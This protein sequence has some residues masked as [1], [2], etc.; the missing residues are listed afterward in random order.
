MLKK[1]PAIQAFLS[2]VAGYKRAFAI[3]ALFFATSDIVITTIPWM[4]GQLA[5]SLTE[6]HDHIVLWTTLLIAASIGHDILWRTGELLHLKLLLRRGHRFDDEIF[7]SILRQPYGYFIDKFTGKVSSYANTLGREFREMID[8]FNNSYINLVVAMPIIA[9]T[10][11][12]VN[13]YTGIVFVVSLLLMFFAGRGLARAASRAEHKEADERSTMDGYAVDAIA[14]FVS[15]KAF[16]NERREAKHIFGKRDALIKAALFSGIKDIWFWG[17]MSVFVRWIIWPSTFI[18]NVYLFTH[19]QI[20]L[21][22][23]TT[24]LTTIV[25]FSAFVWEVI[26]N[27]SQLNIKLAGIEEAYR[28]LF[29]ERNIFRDPIP[30]AAA[31]LP[32][33][34]FKESLELRGVSFAYPD[35]PEVDVLKNVSMT[36]RQGEKIG[37]VGPSGGGKSTLLKLLLGHYPL[38]QGQLLIDGQPVDNDRLTS[39]TAYVPQDTAVFHRPIG[40]NI[41]YGKPGATKAEIVA[42]AKHAQA[43]EF[44]MELDTGYDTL[45]GERGIKLSGG[46]RQRVAIARAILKGAPLLMLDEAT[47]ALDSESEKAIQA[48]LWQLMKGRT[49]IVIAHRLS[50]IQKM[51][52]ILVLEKGTIV[53]Q[54]THRELLD[55]HGIY[56]KLWSHQSGGFI[57]E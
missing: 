18:L 6:Q 28:Y 2:Y 1:H 14:N 40:E 4:V 33:D 16:G 30:E 24:F 32:N 22:Q 26:W 23:M 48:A 55:N 27:I 7:A 52:R 38:T 49:A 36:I 34:S 43:H 39:L 15:V 57:E 9:A 46:Q 47:S 12:T 13:V 41:S 3:T 44:I 17:T 21:A 8:N 42:A 45:V 29:G 37:I 53:E 54:G 25:L 51:D 56:A 50:T 19:S 20:S 10:M 31:Q 5:R 11:F 35:K